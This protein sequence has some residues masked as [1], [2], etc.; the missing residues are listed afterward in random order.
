MKVITLKIMA[1]CDGDASQLTE[2]LYKDIRDMYSEGDANVV[3]LSARYE[4]PTQEDLSLL[5]DR[6]EN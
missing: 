3:I 5:N 2:E 4:K 6:L 1:L